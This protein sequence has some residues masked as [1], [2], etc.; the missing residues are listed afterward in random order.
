MIDRYEDWKVEAAF[1]PR[2]EWL[3]T[4]SVDSVGTVRLWQLEGDNLPA[5]RVLAELD[6]YAYGLAVSPLMGKVCSWKRFTGCP[7]AVARRTASAP[8]AGR[9][10]IR[11]VDS[12][13]PGRQAWCREHCP[14]KHRLHPYLEHGDR[15][16][17]LGHRAV[18]GN[19]RSA[20]HRLCR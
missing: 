1:G 17:L 2:G 5:G 4:T 20:G 14:G 19:G 16:D 6:S 18:I 12:D 10:D 7:V 9:R 8:A 15:D 13:Q 11:G 3:A